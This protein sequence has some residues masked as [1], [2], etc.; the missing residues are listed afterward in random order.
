ME[1]TGKKVLVLGLARSGAAAARLLQKLGAEVTVNDQKDL[2]EDPLAAELQALGINVIGGGHPEGIV[3]PGL[4]LVV[5]NPGIPYK[6][7]PV[8]Q[9]LTLGIPVV[10][11]VELA[12]EV[13]KAP[14]IGITGSNGKT[15]TTTLVGKMLEAA[16]LHPVVAG[17]IGLALSEVAETVTAD[18][19]LV[20]ELSSFQLMGTQAFRPK[21]GALL[22]LY[23]AHLDYHGTMEEYRD[24]KFRLFANQTEGDTAVLNWDQEEVRLAAQTTQ[25]RLV[26]FSTSEVLEEGVFVQDGHIHAI[27]NGKN[28]PLLPVSE[29]GLAGVH[30][31]QNVLA[32]AAICLAAGAPAE[33]VV[34]VA[35][36][37][38]GVEHRTEYV[39]T[40][41]GVDFYNDSKATNAAAAT[42]AITAFPSVVLIAGGLDRGMDFH[43]LVPVFEKHVKHVVAIGQAADRFLHVA[44]LAGKT[45]EKTD[46]LEAAV[47]LAAER[48]EVGDT[49][50]LSPACASWDMFGS[51]EERGSMFKK[52]VHTL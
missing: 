30:N 24:A 50:L 11:E 52:A 17:N 49:V 22:N 47:R 3:H 29:V 40:K 32:A 14:V 1:Y 13:A 10:T 39:A 20:A 31:L 4:A 51:F 45:A 7:A 28:L 23:S 37:F 34:E 21:I 48:A 27:L 12:Y 8:R 44:N 41:S 9:A 43:E 38:R 46:S 5:K 15:T 2:R 35:R 26:W 16:D 6:A 19:W 36:T 33:A 25:A 18:Q 42:Q